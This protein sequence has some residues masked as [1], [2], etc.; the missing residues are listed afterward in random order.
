MAKNLLVVFALLCFVGSF[1]QATIPVNVGCQ[2]TSKYKWLN[3]VQPASVYQSCTYSIAPYSIYVCQLR[4]EFAT[5]LAQPTSPN[6]IDSPTC[7]NGYIQIGRHKICGVNSNQHLYVDFFGSNSNNRVTIVTNPNGGTYQIKVTQ[8]ECPIGYKT[9][10]YQPTDKLAPVKPI[11]PESK[12]MKTIIFDTDI[13]A[14]SGCDQYYIDTVGFVE[15]FNW[16]NARGPYPGSMQYTVCFRRPVSSSRLRL[17]AMDF[18]LE[19]NAADQT[20]GNC[21]DLYEAT[22]GYSSDY[23]MVPYS[24]ITETGIVADQYCGVILQ[25]RTVESTMFGTF[26][27]TFKAGNYVNGN[28][29]KRVFKFQYQ[30]I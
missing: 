19:Y 17:Y 30:V 6:L 14:P 11:Q 23:V 9:K 26:W 24:R 1:V 27:F 22:P 15:S 10:I 5:V 3:L 18:S 8:V 4:V 21:Y 2:S 16:N 28:N 7:R 20:N 29:V 13:I 12:L 25:S